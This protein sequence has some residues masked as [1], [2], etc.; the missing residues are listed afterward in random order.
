MNKWLCFILAAIIFFLIKPDVAY[1][2]DVVL[3]EFSSGTTDD[4]VEIYNKSSS[5][6]SIEGW[7]IRDST[8]N[9]KSF[10]GSICANSTR[11]IDFSNWLNNNG[12]T[13]RLL[14]SESSSSSQ[15]SVIYPDSVPKNSDGQST[16]RTPDGA[17]NWTVL[18]TPTPNDNNG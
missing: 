10:T 13:I 5:P 1:A 18:T 2:S 16:S 7:V 15:D 17:D 8:D 6:I 9:K 3:N 11:K 4:W 14:D 12:D